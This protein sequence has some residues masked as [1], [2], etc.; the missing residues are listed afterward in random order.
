[1][2]EIDVAIKNLN[3]QEI[4]SLLHT[5]KGN[6]STLG[7]E[8]LAENA[9]QIEYDIKENKTKNLLNQISSLW[10]DFKEFE[11]NYKKLLNI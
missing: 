10:M 1:M 8:R 4:L 9:A 2:T 6:S 7:V 11:K 5:V 3:Y